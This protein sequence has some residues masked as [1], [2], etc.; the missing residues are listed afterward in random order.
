MAIQ[1]FSPDIAL[2]IAVVIYSWNWQMNYVC[3]IPESNMMFTPSL[4][5]CALLSSH[6]LFSIL[7]D[8]VM[9][10]ACVPYWNVTPGLETG[11]IQLLKNRNIENKHF[12]NSVYESI[13]YME[14]ICLELVITFKFQP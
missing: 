5:S 1:H 4:P 2:H 10:F 9:L 6:Y 7:Q 14:V 3:L 11:F 12:Y 13:Y 8:T